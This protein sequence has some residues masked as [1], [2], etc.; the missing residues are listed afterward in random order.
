MRWPSNQRIL[1]CDDE[2]HIVR[3]LQLNLERQGHKVT[4]A[5]GGREAIDLLS[6]E[7]FEVE[8]RPFGWRG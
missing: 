1:V 5:Y 8:G 7:A 4:R 2:W 3:L 6:R